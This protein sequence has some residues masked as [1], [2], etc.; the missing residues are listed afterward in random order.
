MK[1][2]FMK[3]LEEQGVKEDYIRQLCF[4][5][6]YDEFFDETTNPSHYVDGAFGWGNHNKWYNIHMA[7]QNELNK[8][9]L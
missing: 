1:D 8:D 3:F 9:D 6:G 5:Y 7:W 4:N 2:K